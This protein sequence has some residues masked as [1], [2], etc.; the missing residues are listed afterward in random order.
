M[1]VGSQPLGM[2]LLFALLGLGSCDVYHC[3]RYF[4]FFVLNWRSVLVVATGFFCCLCFSRVDDR[5]GHHV[6]DNDANPNDA[7]T[8]I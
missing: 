4:S 8:T 6:G 2:P 5:L 1:I 7:V 3:F